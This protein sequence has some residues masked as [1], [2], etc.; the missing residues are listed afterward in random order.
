MTRAHPAG[1]RTRVCACVCGLNK[2]SSLD[3]EGRGPHRPRIPPTCSPAFT[4]QR[5][6]QPLNLFPWQP[7]QPQRG[8][9]GRKRNAREK[10]NGDIGDRQS[11][12]PRVEPQQRWEDWED[13]GTQGRPPGPLLCCVPSQTLLMEIH[14]SAPAVWISSLPPSHSRAEEQESL[15]ADFTHSST[16]SVFVKA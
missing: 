12:R 2:T 10:R 15:P 13:W 5:S 6:S 1:W 9:C 11:R 4:Q 7:Q 16:E 8:G 3:G 14:T